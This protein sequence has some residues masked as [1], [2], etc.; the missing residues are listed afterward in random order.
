VIVIKS[1]EEIE[2]MKKPGRLVAEVLE[3]IRVHIRPGENT[4]YLDGII[5]E[6]FSQNHAIP[7]FKGYGGFPFSSCI[8]VN[9]VVIHG[10]PDRN[11]VLMEGDLVSIDVGAYVDGFHGDAARTYS[12]GQ[13][14]E[15]ANR[16]MTVT[17][18]ALE[19][20]I[21]ELDKMER[22]GNV[23]YA[24]QTYV[25]GQ[26]FSIIR[27]YVGHGIGKDLHES[28]QIPNYGFPNRGIRLR[29]GM[30][31]AIEPMVSAGDWRTEVLDDGFTAVTVDRSLAA[32]YED[33]VALTENGVEILTRL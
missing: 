2:R 3:M 7:S 28:P 27:E 21:R 18:E 23:S 22:L 20:G 24:I 4:A 15:E 25:E 19:L 13:A 6:F 31:L 12:V 26:G 10:L 17:Q 11:R 1:R 5:E 14:S 29:K 16:L 33:T 8:S 30:T 9:E 32:H